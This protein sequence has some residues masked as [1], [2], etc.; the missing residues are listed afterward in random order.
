MRK[1][2]NMTIFGVS[3]KKY[4]MDDEERLKINKITKFGHEML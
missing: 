3:A 4:A 2:V 1:S